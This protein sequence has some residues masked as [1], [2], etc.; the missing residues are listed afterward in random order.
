MP[1]T[2]DLLQQGIA[3]AKAGQREEAR[4]ILL[5]VVELDE[6]N[7]SAWLWLSGVVDSD[8][9]KTVALENVLALNPNNEWAKRGL[10]ILGRP[11]PGE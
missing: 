11:V 5:Q 4:G 8:D 9:D 10:R 3:Y 2:N 6:Q 1:D 7:E